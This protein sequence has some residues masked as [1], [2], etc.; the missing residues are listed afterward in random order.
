M[1]VKLK[2]ESVGL[3]ITILLTLFA[4]TQSVNASSPSPPDFDLERRAYQKLFDQY[5][6]VDADEV[7]SDVTPVRV[8]SPADL[9]KL[10]QE[11]SGGKQSDILE[12]MPV[13]DLAILAGNSSSDSHSN[14]TIQTSYTTLYRECTV[15]VGLATF[16]TGAHIRVGVSGTSYAWIDSVNEWVGLRGCTLG[17]DLTSTYHYHHTTATTADVTGGGVVDYYIAVEGGIKV[18]SRPVECSIHYSIY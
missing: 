12:R 16:Y 2:W 5:G 13:K 17:L 1:K 18:W 14:P 9:E 6:L 8:S 10:L 11:V 3:I 7:P 15:P 4:T